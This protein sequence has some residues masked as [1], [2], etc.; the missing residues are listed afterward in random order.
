MIGSTRQ[1]WRRRSM[2]QPGSSPK[3]AGKKTVPYPPVRCRQSHLRRTCRY[4][5][6]IDNADRRTAPC[7]GVEMSTDDGRMRVE[8]RQFLASRGAVNKFQPADWRNANQ[9]AVLKV[10][11]SAPFASLKFFYPPRQKRGIYFLPIGN[12]GGGVRLVE[13]RTVCGV[14][15]RRVSADRTFHV[16]KK[17]LWLSASPGLRWAKRTPCVPPM[18][19]ESKNRSPVTVL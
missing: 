2:R 16:T 14:V 3:P 6:G 19:S 5:G 4:A 7:V 15:S 11:I 9:A 10:I 1:G 8:Y 12:A 13:P 17:S 18:P